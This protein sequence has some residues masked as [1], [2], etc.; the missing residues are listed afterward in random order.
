MIPLKLKIQGFLSYRAPVELDFRPLHIACI[1]GENGAGKSSLLDAM[2]WALFGQARKNDASVVNSALIERS[3]PGEKPFAEVAFE[4]EYESVRYQIV[5]RIVVGRL[6]QMTVDFFVF[7]PEK[8]SWTILSEKT[9]RDTDRKIIELLHLEYDT[10]VNASFFL[11]GQADSFTKA[12]ATERKRILSDILNLSVWEIYKKRTQ[13]RE[14]ELK[15]RQKSIS[16]RISALQA[17]L[18]EEPARQARFEAAQGEFAQAQEIAELALRRFQNARDAESLYNSRASALSEETRENDRRFSQLQSDQQLFETRRG[19]LERTRAAL[20]NADQ[21]RADYRELQTLRDRLGAFHAA[22]QR[23]Y[24][25]KQTIQTAE[26]RLQLEEARIA[27]RL[28]VLE[29]NRSELEEAARAVEADAP[30]LSEFEQ[31]LARIEERI[32]EKPALERTLD[33]LNDQIN[34]GITDNRVLRGQM[35]E[36]KRHLEDFQ[37]KEGLECPFCGRE[38]DAAHCRAYEAELTAKGTELGNTYRANKA[39]NERLAAEKK[40]IDRSITEIRQLERDKIALESARLPLVVRRDGYLTK[41]RDWEAGERAEAEDLAARLNAQSFGS[42]DRERITEARAALE[43]LAYDREAHEAAEGRAQELAEA[44]SAYQ[45]VERAAAS[46]AQL[47]RDVGER[48]ERLEA[49]RLAY[50]RRVEALN[51]KR[52]ELDEMRKELPDVRHAQNEYEAAHSAAMRLQNELGAARQ[53]LEALRDLRKQQLSLRAAEADTANQ[54]RIIAKLDLAFSPKGI[55][56]LLIDEALPEIEENANRIL[57]QLTEDRMSVRL[58]TQGEYKDKKRTDARETLDILIR[59]ESG[60]RDYELFSGGEAFRVNFAI[61]LALS[62]LLTRRAG[63]RL[64][65]LVIDEGFGSQ[66]AD[67]RQRLIEAIHTIQ[68]DFEKILVITHLEELK[69]AFQ[70]RIEVLKGEDGSVVR[71][72][73]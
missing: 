59:D 70:S 32:A 23:Y 39:L 51:E 55:P 15:S 18:E 44:E 41:K 4:F 24:Q 52:A 43:A 34:D 19:E 66:D 62:A 38:M 25:L 10:F 2:T 63:S 37:A 68:D 31:R 17:E 64:Q 22:S 53:R 54:L 12:N 56:A 49:D 73:P 57:G 7:D 13:A 21:V 71:V 58:T 40:E 9:R 50:H 26:H 72:I 35:E 60:T 27:S 3:R 36:I 14:T 29:K 42:E 69:D 8:E 6:S 28:S 20:S 30:R 67:G 1:T 33:E 11:Q 45:A 61:R 46:L 47:E 5:R 48:G 16:D 65:L